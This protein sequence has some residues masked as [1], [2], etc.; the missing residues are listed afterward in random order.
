[1]NRAELVVARKCH[2]G[3]SKESL[4]RGAN[5]QAYASDSPY[6]CDPIHVHLRSGDCG[7]CKGEGFEN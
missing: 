1:M 2:L 3:F 5:Q 7:T 4:D 6:G